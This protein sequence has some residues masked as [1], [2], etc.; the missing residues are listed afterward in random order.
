[1]SGDGG[2][3]VKWCQTHSK[4][5]L[6]A[7]SNKSS[8]SWLSSHIRDPP[9]QIKVF[10]ESS[11]VRTFG[12]FVCHFISFLSFSFETA[13][14]SLNTSHSHSS[15]LSFS[16]YEAVHAAGM[17]FLLQWQQKGSALIKALPSAH[18]ELVLKVSDETEVRHPAT[19]SYGPSS[20][21]IWEASHPSLSPLSHFILQYLAVFL[22]SKSQQPL[23]MSLNTGWDVFE[24]WIKKQH[25]VTKLPQQH[26]KLKVFWLAELFLLC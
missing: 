2:I 9:R 20:P 13:F 24:L 22:S 4:T 14:L 7:A 21:L 19:L 17:H 10:C 23:S 12:L 5:S 16:V 1:M 15:S 18:V 8:L 26:I 25:M 3:V 11:H 6:I